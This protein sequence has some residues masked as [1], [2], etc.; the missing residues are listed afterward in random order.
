MA[1]SQL[2]MQQLHIYT[3]HSDFTTAQIVINCMLKYA[4]TGTLQTQ[5]T[6]APNLPLSHCGVFTH[7]HWPNFCKVS[8]SPSTSVRLAI[9]QSRTTSLRLAIRRLLLR[10]YSLL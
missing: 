4:L 1:I 5:G 3:A 8:H 10:G 7:A 9:D 6:A 2:T